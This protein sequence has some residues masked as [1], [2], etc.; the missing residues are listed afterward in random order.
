[1]NTTHLTE[2]E[3]QQYVLD[4]AAVNIEVT[5]H[6]HSCVLC[7][8]KAAAYQLLFSGLQ[9]QSQ[10][11]F[12]FNL[13]ELVM[14][15]LPLPATNPVK[16]NVLIYFFITAAASITGFALYYFRGYVVTLFQSIAPAFIYLVVTAF[17]TMTAFLIADMY[18][19]YKKKMH[20][21]DFNKQ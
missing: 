6:I 12:D 21:L 17:I 10:A 2:D 11:S 3:I 14:P 5:E 15:Q 1:M 9:Q 20:I 4:D 19:S 16:E 8:E 18:K 7:K 13:E